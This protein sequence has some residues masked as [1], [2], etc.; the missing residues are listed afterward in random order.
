MA[1]FDDEDA[2]RWAGEDLASR[3]A[4]RSRAR[5]GG[6]RPHEVESTAEVDEVIDLSEG[7]ELRGASSLTLV[8]LGVL[9]GIYFLY[10]LGWLTYALRSVTR[11]SVDPL[12][13]AMFNT[14]LGLSVLAAPLW[15]ALTFWLIERSS[16]RYAVLVLG[17][18]VLIPIPLVWPR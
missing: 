8:T 2:L 1:E 4:E 10:A 15:F 18:L 3:P 13:A 9:G 6:R 11:S 17:A 12:A 5:A 16:I 7:E 14:G